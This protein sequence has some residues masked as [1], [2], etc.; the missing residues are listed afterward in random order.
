MHIAEIKDDDS[1]ELLTGYFYALEAW[2]DEDAPKLENAIYSLGPGEVDPLEMRW[3]RGDKWKD[4]FDCPVNNSH[5]TR[6]EL[7]GINVLLRN[8]PELPVAKFDDNLFVLRDDIYASLAK[9]GLK[10]LRGVECNVVEDNFGTGTKNKYWCL[11]Y[12][13]KDMAR[14]PVVVPLSANKCAFCG[15]G[16]L[17]CPGC[18]EVL[19]INCPMCQK[20]CVMYQGDEQKPNLAA[21]V[22]FHGPPD[23][24]IILDGSR[25]D[26]TDF[27][28]CR[29]G[30]VVT[31]RV[32]SAL[33]KIHAYA[34]RAIALRT[35]VGSCTPAQRAE[36][37]KL[38][39][40]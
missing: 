5:I 11:C 26:G 29:G 23:L 15:Q 32:V 12:D 17:V 10:G 4:V 7:Q 40:S 8:G 22:L 13:G 20:R 19:F 34:F 6:R 28:E 31:R 9:S 18:G 21:P 35:Y 14:M 30:Y 33:L 1:G 39:D 24:G 38:K 37:E 25:W 36:L 3:G 2:P 16:P 27:L